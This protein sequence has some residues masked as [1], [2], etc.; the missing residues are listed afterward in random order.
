MGSR[1]AVF[2]GPSATI[3]NTPPLVTSNKARRDHELPLLRD[4][5]GRPLPDVLRPQRIAAP[6]TVYVEQFSAH[7]L[8]ADAARLYAEPDGYLDAAGTFSAVRTAS[9]DRPVYRVTLHPE[10][11][12][13][14]LP[15][16]A[17]QQDGSAWEDDAAHPNATD[18]SARQP[19]FPD[20]AR[21][22]EEVD[23]LG[24][25]NRG[26]GGV[27]GQLAT[28]DFFRVLPS[29]GYRR[30]GGPDAP[31]IDGD[32][33]AAGEVRGVDFFP[34]RPFHLSVKP[35]RPGLARVANAVRDV[36]GSG[37]Y[38]G[39]LWLEA[40][41]TI[42]ETLYW[43]SLVLDLDVPLV[44]VAAH[45][46]HGVIGSDGPRQLVDAV[47]YVCCELWRGRDG[48]DAIG[49]VVIS[50]QL[51]FAARGLEKADA[52]P[53]GYRT[54]GFGGPIGVIPD[55]GEP[56][57]QYR[58]AYRR[59]RTSAVGMRA[60]PDVVRGWR[61]GDSAPVAVDVRVTDERRRLNGA[62]IP[63]VRIVK[64][65]S[66][67]AEGEAPDVAL[68]RSIASNLESAP[69]AGFIAEGN[70][71][72]ANMSP[73]VDAALREAVRHGMPVVCV[74]RG[75]PEGPLPPGSRRPFVTGADLSAT[76]ARILLIAC[77]LRFGA[78]PV[79]IDAHAPTDDEQREL[80]DAVRA[81]Q[82]VFD[83]H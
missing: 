3:L 19:F 36:L 39:A 47:R 61:A 83:S 65:G 68:V 40:S 7:P 67:S 37:D 17:R 27:L 44:G 46:Q 24:L 80:R 60:M 43:L 4:R 69:L 21:L 58:P 51:V 74:G 10:D 38:D 59:G 42:E 14:P 50:D 1:I 32:E 54:A 29:A 71:P 34:Y 41:P 5:E 56:V 22:F 52:R 81:Y 64:D 76:K 63:T 18:E 75:S 82:E 20:A 13:Y 49:P 12:L 77:L 73:G 66:Y 11:G 35:S 31:P 30:G 62:T 72:Y 26:V 8:E 48:R 15:Y 57:L 79:A 55:E 23:R 33:P 45:R 25:G 70:T 16:M 2:A 9:A 6:V 78:L 28:F 53:G